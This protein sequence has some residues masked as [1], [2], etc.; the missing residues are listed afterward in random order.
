[1][2]IFWFL[3]RRR[4]QRHA[5][6]VA[7]R[8]ESDAAEEILT[9]LLETLSDE[10]KHNAG[11][12]TVFDAALQA[13]IDLLQERPSRKK[14]DELLPFLKLLDTA[15]ERHENAA[16]EID[17][18]SHYGRL[19]EMMAG[20]S[21]PIYL[22]MLHLGWDAARARPHTRGECARMRA[23]AMAIS[24]EWEEL[25]SDPAFAVRKDIPAPVLL[26]LAEAHLRLGQLPESLD[27][28]HLPGEEA[29]VLAD[30]IAVEEAILT[31]ARDIPEPPPD[32]SGQ[33][34][35]HLRAALARVRVRAALARGSSEAARAALEAESLDLLPDAEVLHLRGLVALLS[36][37]LDLAEEHL[38]EAHALIPE[39]PLVVAARAAVRARS[40]ATPREIAEITTD[41]DH[42]ACLLMASHAAVL[43]GSHR[44][45]EKI[46]DT[47]ADEP[48]LR[49][50][51]EMAYAAVLWHRRAAAVAGSSAA[52]PAEDTH[53]LVTALRRAQ[54]QPTRHGANR[55]D[56]TP[57]MAVARYWA[58]KEIPGD[59]IPELTASLSRRDEPGF[60]IYRA[61]AE[62][63]QPDP[64]RSFEA[65]ERLVELVDEH[66]SPVREQGN[67]F[68]R[69]A[70]LTLAQITSPTTWRHTLSATGVLLGR[71]NAWLD[72]WRRA[73]DRDG[74]HQEARHP[75]H[76]LA[77]A[78]GRRDEIR[79]WLEQ[80][81][82]VADSTWAAMALAAMATAEDDI[83]AVARL[84]RA[85]PDNGEWARVGAFLDAIIAWHSDDFG[86]YRA[87][88]SSAANGQDRLSDLAGAM[89]HFADLRE[90][91]D[92]A[93]AVALLTHLSA[94]PRA[95]TRSLDLTRLVAAATRAY[96]DD[97]SHRE[98]LHRA[99]GDAAAVDLPPDGLRPLA[100]LAAAMGRDAAAR[101]AFERAIDAGVDEAVEEYQAYLC[102]QAVMVAR[103]QTRQ[104]AAP[105]LS[106]ALAFNGG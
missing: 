88:I 75:A 78:D 72:I 38:E 58:W 6:E 81:P 12:F 10:K 92:D 102:H 86:H 21:R 82:E 94:L 93:A 91:G 103:E 17:I 51:R 9:S 84:R 70:T 49:E 39:N 73:I 47:V 31:G 27:L 83:D 36:G 54:H 79:G 101:S 104:D 71:Q 59:K 68:S 95:L 67:T 42:P 3:T 80:E 32:D 35:A 48:R 22:S 97:R 34:D 87:S 13:R 56:L 20:R 33:L 57:F 98:D 1:M 15:D 19:A 63:H 99:I 100:H 77:F 5:I 44:K 85:V 29:E 7:Q 14:I 28:S 23:C 40:A 37:E 55:A 41:Q 62:A 18:A 25:A 26:R 50:A 64:Q 8:N 66:L 76:G 43:A 45:A 24:G 4:R 16:A 74:W 30:L 89:L 60:R 65:L 61:L 90:N 52:P 46:L 106:E 96:N 69:L 11:W 53:A 2:G 105:L